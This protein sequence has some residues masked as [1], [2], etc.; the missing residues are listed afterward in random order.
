MHL[1][2]VL[3]T[4]RRRRVGTLPLAA[5]AVAL[6]AAGC[7]TTPPLV[8]I[9]RGIGGAAPNFR[10]HRGTIS[11]DGN[12]IAFTSQATNL[13]PGDTN[14]RRDVFVHDRRT[15]HTER[16]NVS[17]DG[18][19]ADADALIGPAISGDGRFVVFTSTA[20]NL[21]DGDTDG[22]ADVFVHELATG[23][24]ERVSVAGVGFPDLTAVDG[25]D[26]WISDDGDLIAFLASD[27]RST[28]RVYLHD[29]PGHRTFVA[30]GRVPTEGLGLGGLSGDGQVMVG[31]DPG[32]DAG[33]EPLT[34]IIRDLAT[35]ADDALL[36]PYR[37]IIAEHRVAMDRTGRFIVWA[38]REESGRF[39]T[40]LADRVERTVETLVDTDGPAAYPTISGDGRYVTVSAPDLGLA[41]VSVLD[42]Q[43]GSRRRV[44]IGYWTS[45]SDDGGAVVIGTA[46][47]EGPFLWLRSG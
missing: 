21:V 44:G 25:F 18:E 43:D 47:N 1:L 4:R 12:V 46:N 38:G 33:F 32:G 35:G 40:L 7:V 29:R 2:H 15:D 11:N 22:T 20:S 3:R 27:S 10:S 36:A 28:A 24:T 26:P 31:L 16:V 45:I 9:P 19:Q 42:R 13:V 17:S 39:R 8:L 23:A 6:L 41:F 34:P 30:P 37:F 14:L 5:L